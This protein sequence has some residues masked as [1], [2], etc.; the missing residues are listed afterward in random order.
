MLTRLTHFILRRTVKRWFDSDTDVRETRRKLDAF[1]GRTDRLRRGWV[2]TAQGAATG[3]AQEA[4][5][6]Q[7][8]GSGL[9]M[10]APKQGVAEDAPL[11]VYLHGGGYMVG[12]LASHA[13]FCS[14]L[15]HA[16]GGR[17]LF[18]DYRLAPE[19]PFP[20]AFEDGVAAW[21]AAIGLAGGRLYIA[22]DSAGGGLALAV[23]QAA[24]AGGLRAPDGL[25]LLSP[26]TDLTLS[27]K[28]LSDNAATD[29]MLSRKIL[30]KMRD[31]YLAGGEPGDRRDSPL[32]D[33]NV[34]LP[35]TLVIYSQSEVLRDDSTRLAKKLRA[36]G[37]EVTAEVFEGVP[38]VFP[39]LTTVPAGKRA[40]K[41]VRAWVG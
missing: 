36:G 28:S 7:Q 16:L 15:G 33:A 24:L 26:W 40:L 41:K 35:R 30:T 8:A 18:V 12:G 6:P 31:L 5:G 34:K 13:A 17:V 25:I 22:G 14:R 4:A 10:I 1:I 37:T 38:H 9:H 23:A 2:V 21:Q 19:H 32:F 3:A 11:I 39:L 20:A 29:S 27:G